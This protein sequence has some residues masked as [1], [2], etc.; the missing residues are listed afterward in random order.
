ME[1]NK[2]DN[3]TMSSQNISVTVVLG[4]W[5]KRI[6]SDSPSGTYALRI[7][8]IQNDST[9]PH[10]RELMPVLPSV[11]WACVNRVKGR[12]CSP[13]LKHPNCHFALIRDLYIGIG[14][15]NL[16]AILIIRILVKS[17]PQLN[18]AII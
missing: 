18:N 1:N 10:L 4:Q 3:S 6:P 2:T 12:L 15:S 14:G 5:S 7:M 11:G 16:L 13:V 17:L 9:T 8:K